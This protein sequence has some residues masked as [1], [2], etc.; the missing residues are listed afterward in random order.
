MTKTLAMNLADCRRPES[1]GEST[2]EYG[3]RTVKE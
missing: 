2:Y 1:A 3:M